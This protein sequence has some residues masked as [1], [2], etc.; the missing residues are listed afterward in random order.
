MTRF[1]FVSL[2]DFPKRK[3]SNHVLTNLTHRLAAASFTGELIAEHSSQGTVKVHTRHIIG[4][5]VLF[6]RSV[7]NSIRSVSNHFPF[8]HP[9]PLLPFNS[10]VLLF[11]SSF[12]FFSPSHHRWTAIQPYRRYNSSMSST[13]RIRRRKRTTTAAPSEKF[14]RSYRG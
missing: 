10:S 4:L 7:P 2:S 8:S 12:F 13:W 5:S 14:Y 9:S 1:L 11:F 6:R 3:K